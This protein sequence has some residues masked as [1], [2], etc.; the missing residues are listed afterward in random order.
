M[1]RRYV[2]DLPR[3]LG[4]AT[5]DER[6]GLAQCFVETVVLKPDTRE[7]DMQ[8]RLPEECVN[9]WRRRPDSNR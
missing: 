5:N 7:I 8:L 4:H 9:H 3:V 1:L 2:D 6:R